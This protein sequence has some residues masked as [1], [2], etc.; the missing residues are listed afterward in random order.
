MVALPVLQLRAGTAVNPGLGR[1]GTERASLTLSCLLWE[2]RRCTPGL[3]SG[4]G[5]GPQG[6]GYSPRYHLPMAEPAVVFLW[7]SRECL[8][9]QAG[10][11][12]LH[13][14]TPQ[15]GK[16][17]PGG[18]AGQA[19]SPVPACQAREA[20]GPR[21]G[22]GGGSWER[23]KAHPAH[24]ALCPGPGHIQTLQDARCPPR[25]QGPSRAPAEAWPLVA[26]GVTQG[27]WGALNLYSAVPHS[28]LAYL[29]ALPQG[30]ICSQES[31]GQ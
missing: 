13:T 25:S 1:H 10:C 31:L 6:L 5:E 15:G 21:E 18:G 30:P 3:E 9:L 16:D 23:C 29:I 14:A 28:S 24:M 19:A 7:E 27:I 12:S 4:R 2:V 8:W 26:E 17:E 11:P 20:Q 22:Q